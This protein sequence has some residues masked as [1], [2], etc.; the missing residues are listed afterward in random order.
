[1]AS[2]YELLEKAERVE[3][4]AER[5]YRTLAG[6][7]AGD[8]RALFL[9]LAGEEAQHASRV[10]LLA[11]RYRHDK[12][13]V[14]ALAADLTLVERLL[15]EAGEAL[16]AVEA[17]AWDGDAGA[18]LTSALALEHRFC[19]VHA[20]ILSQDAHPELRAFFDQLAAQDQAHLELLGPLQ[21]RT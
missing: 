8:A 18:A 15:R 16:Q 20:Q 2:T 14:A 3:L 21:A 13:L 12:R 4:T 9:R 17:G 10:R 19:E 5:I 6:R 11:A 1:M 7:F